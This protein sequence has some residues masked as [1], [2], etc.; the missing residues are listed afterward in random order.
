MDAGFLP[1][2]SLVLHNGIAPHQNCAILDVLAAVPVDGLNSSL[3]GRSVLLS[4]C[5]FITVLIS[6]QSRVVEPQ[7]T[8]YPGEAIDHVWVV[9]THS[10][11][12]KI[13]ERYLALK[14]QYF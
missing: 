9:L 5:C 7:Q 2:S 6:D 4:T 14:K 3:S 1:R 8:T 10:G 12:Q 11:L 13:Y